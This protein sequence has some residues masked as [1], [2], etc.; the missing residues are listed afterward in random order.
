MEKHQ[1]ELKISA[2]QQRTLAEC[3]AVVGCADKLALIQEE[4][5][6]EAQWWRIQYFQDCQER[7]HHKHLK[8]E[9]RKI[10]KAKT[11]R[12][13]SYIWRN[14]LEDTRTACT[15]A[16]FAI[17]VEASLQQCAQHML[18]KMAEGMASGR[19]EKRW[20]SPMIHSFDQL[21]VKATG[22]V[23]G[24]Y[25]GSTRMLW[26]NTLVACVEGAPMDER[27]IRALYG[28]PFVHVVGV[29]GRAVDFLRP[30]SHSH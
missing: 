12:E 4:L 1:V 21:W 24:V 16:T 6:F 17:G 23:G 29:P 19:P 27:N 8:S 10:A 5:A 15:V 14:G 30:Q 13:A 26:I 25:E 9:L 22:G 2:E 20:R 3:L 28:Q 7:A 11:D 18:D